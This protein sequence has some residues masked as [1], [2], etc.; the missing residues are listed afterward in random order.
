MK[1]YKVP[2]TWREYGYVLIEANSE[3]EA[4]RL[5]HDADLPSDSEYLEGSFEIDYDNI[6]CIENEIKKYSDELKK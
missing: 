5:T 3:A 6:K 4:I 1:T 2:V